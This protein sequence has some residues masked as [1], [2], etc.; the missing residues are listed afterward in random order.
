MLGRTLALLILAASLVTMGARADEDVVET[1]DGVAAEKAWEGVKEPVDI[2]FGPDGS[3]YYAEL[4]TGNLR[5]IAPGASAPEPEPVWTAP[6]LQAGGERG[7][8]GLALDPEFERT[9]AFYVY[10]TANESGA[11][12]GHL[13]RVIDGEEERLLTIERVGL[14]HNSGRIA[15]MPDGHLLL[16]VGDAILDTAGPHLAEHSHDPA[17]PNG[18]IL[19]LTR[20]GEPAPGNPWDTL[21]WTKGHRNVYGLAVSPEGVVIATENG[22]DRGDEINLL[23]P[24]K[25][26]GWPTCVAAC[27]DPAFEEPV[28]WWEETV[29]PTGATWY[30][31]S[32]Y[33]SAFNTG[34]VHRLVAPSAEGANWTMER[35]VKFASPRV[36]DIEAGPDGLYASSWDT[37]WRIMGL[38]EGAPESRPVTPAVSGQAA[39]PAPTQ[40]SAPVADAPTPGAGLAI[41]LLA[42]VASAL[43]AR[44]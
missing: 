34:S 11:V 1:T 20:D 41:A 32:F 10:Y 21:A 35:V 18:K 29:A 40:E 28:L 2:A 7:F 15:F 36:I 42:V 12:R 16:S 37:V 25:D 43:A 5:V 39:E 30:A 23:S 26:Y 27:G 4:T 33:F 22:P 31:G 17:D 6:D 14:L 9:R 38:P 13:S 44:R 8:V 3:L 24:G 19:R